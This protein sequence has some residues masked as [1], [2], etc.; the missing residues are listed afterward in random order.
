MGAGGAHCFDILLCGL[1][2]LEEYDFKNFKGKL[3]DAERPYKIPLCKLENADVP[4]LANLMI[5]HFDRKQAVTTTKRIL[6]D[7][8]LKEALNIMIEKAKKL[9]KAKGKKSLEKKPKSHP[10]KNTGQNTG[11]CKNQRT[12]NEMIKEPFVAKVIKVTKPLKYRYSDGKRKQVFHALVLNASAKTRIKIFDA[13]KHPLFKKN[14]TI[15][16]SN[17]YKK[18]GYLQVVKHSICE[19]KEE[20]LVIPKKM[21]KD[22]VKRT[23][24][25]D[26]WEMPEKSYVDGTFTVKEKRLGKGYTCFTVTDDTGE[27]E[28]MVFDEVGN[29]KA[30]EGDK[31]QLTWFK[32]NVFNS[33]LQLKSEMHSRIQV[34]KQ[35]KK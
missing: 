15:E 18:E 31:L 8:H 30:A 11:S 10:A 9:S 21:H 3:S 13:E 7:L 2:N 5:Q 6:R 33:K 19:I 24:I 14:K 32:R 35:R 4:T 26:I 23:R 34:K 25:E 12:K 17:Y 1:S 27:I 29:V 22:A 28:V 16:I 20:E